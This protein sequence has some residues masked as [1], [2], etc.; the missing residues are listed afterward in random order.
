M[1]KIAQYISKQ[2]IKHTVKEYGTTAVLDVGK[3]VTDAKFTHCSITF[4]SHAADSVT[5]RMYEN[6]E[7]NSKEI[8][9]IDDKAQII[10]IF[11][12]HDHKIKAQ[13]DKIISHVSIMVGGW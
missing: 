3:A 1:S 6:K 2:V 11:K 5:V 8:R 4:K 10:M 7:L 13:I 12:L 9:I